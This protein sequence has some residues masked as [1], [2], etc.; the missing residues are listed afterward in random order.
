MNLIDLTPLLSL[1]LIASAIV[2]LFSKACEHME[3]LAGADQPDV[4]LPRPEPTFHSL[5]DVCKAYG[6]ANVRVLV[7]MQPLEYK[8]FIPGIA[9]RSSNSV[10]EVTECVIHESRYTMADGYKVELRAVDYERFG[11][12]S[13]YQSDLNHILRDAW[14]RGDASYR[15]FVHTIDGAQEVTL[16]FNVKELS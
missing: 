4:P 5:K 16:G 1:V 12:E 15:I 3:I 11:K 8:G 7:P 2:L 13:Y 9:F 6:V 10:G 14:V